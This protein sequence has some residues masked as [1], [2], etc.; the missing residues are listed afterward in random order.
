MKLYHGSMTAGI[1]ELQPA[2]SNHGKPYVYLT[3]NEALSVIYS[4]NPMT[5]PNGWF[6]YCWREGRLHYDEYFPNAL[7]EI[8]RGHPGYV[9]TC[10]GD[11]P[12]MEKMPWVYLSEE[13]VSVLTERYIPDVYEELLRLSEAGDMVIN[14][15]EKISDRFKAHI[16]ELVRPKETDDE[17]Y[18][19]FVRKYFPGQ[20][21]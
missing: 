3:D 19:S 10:E 18:R 11:F 1:R 4:Y 5:R 12:N 20:F 9:Y 16:L 15:Y 6:T 2:L 21:D 17:N 8:Y 7:E 13:A 14:R